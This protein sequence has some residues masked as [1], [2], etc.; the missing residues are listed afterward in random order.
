MCFNALFKEKRL[1]C[2]ITSKSAM[3]MQLTA[4]VL[5]TACIQVSASSLYAQRISISGKNIPLKKVFNEI[6]EQTGYNFIYT[7]EDLKQA[8]SVTLHQKDA[9]LSD[10]LQACFNDQPLAYSIYKNIIIVKLKEQIQ[11]EP[12]MIRQIDITGRVVDSVTGNGLAGVTIQVRESTIGTTTGPDGSFSLS[13]PDNAVLL[14]SYLGYQ[15][16]TVHVTGSS[17]QIALAPTTTGLNQLVVVGYGTQK[18]SDLTGAIT[19][20]SSDQYKTQPVTRLDQ[21]LQGRAAGVEVTNATGAPGGD[22]RIRIRGANSVLGNNDPLYVVDGFVGADFSTIN[23]NNIASIQ[24][25]KDASSTA[26]YGSRG[27]NGV[28]IITTKKGQKGAINI[29]YSGKVS[30]SRVLRTYDLL[31]AGEFAE[32]VNTRNSVLGLNP[33]YTQDQINDFKQNG[34][35]DWQKEVFRDALGHEHELSVS[36]GGDKTTYFISGDY[37]SQEG[38]IEASDYKRYSLRS[39]ISTQITDKLTFNLNVSVNSQTNKN[40]QLQ[41]GTGNPAVQALVWAPTTPIYQPNGDYVQIDPVGSLKTNPVAL[42]YDRNNLVTRTYENITGNARYEFIDGLA[43]EVTYVVNHLNENDK[44]FNGMT[45]T[46]GNPSASQTSSEGLTLQETNT[47]SY[48]H[49]FPGGHT[50]DAVAV[51]ETQE[52]H[53]NS[54]NATGTGLLIPALGY[55]NLGLSASPA[56]SSGPTPWSL[57]SKLARVNYSYKDKYLFTASIRRD[58]SS[59]FRGEN[60]YSTFPALALGWNLTQENFIKDMNVFSHLKIRASWGKT[61]SQAIQPFATQST[62]NTTIYA[63][64]NNDLTS[65]ILLGNPGNPNLKWETTDQK[66][67]GLEVG[68]LGGRLNL[69]ADYYVKHTTDLLLNRPLPG[70]VGGGSYA[71]NVGEIENKGWDLSIGGEIIHEGTFTWTSHFNISN[72]QNRVV[73]IGKDI[74]DRIFTGS[75]VGAGTST[76]S[77]F[78]IQPGYALGAYWGLKSLGTWK[79]HDAAEAA[80]YHN[81]PGDSRY[82]DVNGDS[83]IN[84]EDYQIIGNGMPKTS[85]GWN[86]TFTY[87]AFTLNFFFQGIMGVDKMNYSL[88]SMMSGSGDGRQITVAMIRNRYIPGKNETS[89][90]PAFSKSN[91]VYPQSSRFLEDGSFIR[92]K[93]VSLAYD[94]PLT[95]FRRKADLKLFLAGSNLWTITKYDGIDPEASNIGSGTDINQSIDYGAYPNSKTIT[96]GL[97][98]GF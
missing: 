36:G 14:V 11:P 17:L 88:A 76:Q 48:K 35:T 15:T 2:F 74:G 4:I 92:L 43:L 63:F 40:T 85:M 86:N 61:G 65:G 37:L 13:A 95:V 29:N 97:N 62:Y 71:S 66:D 67:I 72:V 96:F 5:L 98:F 33:T 23:P 56:I 44:S 45:V 53:G 42:L 58:G 16:K 91:V 20:I 70:Y 68:I 50:I 25:L 55:D 60:R 69:E 49:T 75:N 84:A 22:V 52:Y 77:E 19:T 39:N 9:S 41:S 8:S 21:V 51:F 30:G 80:I 78:V 93:N 94:I 79:P 26:I 10:V 27:A 47:L 7:N 90:I 46:N 18:K 24:V 31:S 59:K 28:V 3:V 6:R 1:L 54:F 57:I 64:N 87:K 83:A 89:N 81:V 34:G 12:L 32:L 73:S 82:E 38:T